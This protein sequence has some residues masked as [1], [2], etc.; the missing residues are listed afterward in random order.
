MPE[1]KRT[2]LTDKEK[3]RI[4]EN[5]RQPGFVVKICWKIKPLNCGLPLISGQFY[6]DKKIH[7]WGVP[8]YPK[9]I[10]MKEWIY[11]QFQKI[12]LWSPEGLHWHD[13][14]IITPPKSQWYWVKSNEYKIF[15]IRNTLYIPEITVVSRGCFAIVW[16]CRIFVLQYP[17]L[18]FVHICCQWHFNGKMIYGTTYIQKVIYI[19]ALQSTNHW[20]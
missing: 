3:L 2:C 20:Q 18:S 14:A 16:P 13:H 10:F 15:N 1:K 7:Y 8:V 11:H 5:S 9:F 4:I 17:W 19:L 6:P 12:D